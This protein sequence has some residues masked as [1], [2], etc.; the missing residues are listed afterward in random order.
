MKT[1]LRVLH[2]ITAFDRGGAENHLADL[3]RHQRDCGMEVTR[4]ISCAG[5][6]IGRRG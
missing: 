4:R 3:V 1:A 6:A 5:R 2:V